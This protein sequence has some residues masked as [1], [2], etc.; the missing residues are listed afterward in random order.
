MVA[1]IRIIVTDMWGLAVYVTYFR[2]EHQTYCL[3]MGTRKGEELRMTAPQ[4]PFQILS[5]SN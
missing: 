2:A 1:W 3:E 5:L 4:L